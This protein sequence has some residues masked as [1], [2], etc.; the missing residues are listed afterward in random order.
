MALACGE[1][2]YNDLAIQLAKAVHRHF[3][4]ATPGV[5]SQPRLE[6]VVPISEDDDG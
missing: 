2:H 5:R 4:W 6:R 1:T 3:V